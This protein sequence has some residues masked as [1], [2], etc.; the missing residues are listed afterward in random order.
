VGN[1]GTALVVNGDFRAPAAGGGLYQSVETVSIGR[2]AIFGGG[3]LSQGGGTLAVGGNL[4]LN[5]ATNLTAG[6]L[7][8]AGNFSHQ[9]GF[10]DGNRIFAQKEHTLW[11]NGITDTD[12]LRVTWNP[13][14]ECTSQLGTV[15]VATTGNKG[16]TIVATRPVYLESLQIVAGGKLRVPQDVS[17]TAAYGN[18]AGTGVFVQEGGTLTNDGSV[19]VIL[20]SGDNCPVGSGVI[21]G[22]F[23]CANHPM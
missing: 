8:L 10:C 3:A 6:T 17:V 2:H 22:P 9:A 15:K 23:I 1:T 18:F 11:F 16:L 13:D 5:G 7:T 12:T 14:G 21:P 4:T 19:T 20:G